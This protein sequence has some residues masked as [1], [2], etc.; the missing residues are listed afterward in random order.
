MLL[1]IIIIIITIVDKIYYKNIKDLKQFKKY[2]KDCKNLVKY[3]RNK[4]YNKRSYISVCLSALNM[5]NYIEKNLLSIL[6]QSF[7]DFEII[8]VNDFST[9][10][11]ENIINKIQLED[12]RIKLIS[13]TKNYGVYRSR[14]EALLNSNSEYALLMDP[15]DMYLNENLFQELYDYNKKN[16]FDI[17]EFSVYQQHDGHS[18][19][20]YPD[21]HFETHY[22][23]FSKHIIYQP[24]LSN[25]LYYIPGTK[26]YSHTICRNIWNKLI[27]RELYIKANKY[28]GKE[29]YDAFII[30]A[31]DMIMNIVTYNFAKNYT[32]IE[33]P[34]YLYII[35]KV[36][37]SRGDGGIKLK[38]IR[39]MNHLLYF[40][41][42]YKYILEYNKDMN[43]LFYEMKD[44]N[45]F[46]IDIKDC[47]MTKYIADGKNFI[48]KIRSDKNI[49]DEFML[50]LE[51]ITLYFTN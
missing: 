11:T 43:F 19:I 2:V 15:D 4:K 25:I 10:S 7:Q 31:D 51:K 17:I 9:D 1:S 35:R 49:S 20:Y 21:N 34:G 8:I 44:L 29:Y 3:K 36:S 26:I 45:R 33:L 42:F 38:Q 23:K 40:K 5:S 14:I 22:H 16:N 39:A 6:N 47:N 32:N 41:I 13:H 50:Y 37:M 12:D 46:L 48:N 27:R 18:K 28:I 30:T 24:E